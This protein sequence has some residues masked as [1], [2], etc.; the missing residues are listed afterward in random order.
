MNSSA[1]G[2][3]SRKVPAPSAGKRPPTERV[4]RSLDDVHAA[5]AHYVAN[6]PYDQILS[7]ATGI[8]TDIDLRV[9]S[10]QEMAEALGRRASAGP[11]NATCTPPTSTKPI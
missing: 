5:I 4:I 8:S 10:D 11:G 9:V 3:R 7:V 1:A 6:I 2:G